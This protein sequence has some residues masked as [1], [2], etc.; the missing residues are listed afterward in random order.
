MAAPIPLVPPVTMATWLMRYPSLY[1]L[2]INSA[3]CGSKS[4]YAAHKQCPTCC[5]VGSP[6][7]ILLAHPGHRF[8]DQ[9]A[10]HRFVDVGEAL[11]VEAALAGLVLAEILHQRI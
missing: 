2:S 7:R 4:N 1:E 3:P 8:A 10:Q 5:R 9:F 6:C 11:D